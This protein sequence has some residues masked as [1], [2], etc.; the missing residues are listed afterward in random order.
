MKNA[1]GQISPHHNDN[2]N[3]KTAPCLI[4]DKRNKTR[5]IFPETQQEHNLNDRNNAKALENI[6]EK[7]LLIKGQQ[8]VVDGGSFCKV[9]VAQLANVIS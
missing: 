4:L 5:D 1:T 2:S 3:S 7:N 8:V 6:N 9:A